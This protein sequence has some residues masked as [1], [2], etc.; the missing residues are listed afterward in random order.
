MRVLRQR[1]VKARPFGRWSLG[2][3][4]GGGITSVATAALLAYCFATSGLV[5]F[6]SGVPA[7]ASVDFGLSLATRQLLSELRAPL[8]SIIVADVLA[9]IWCWLRTWDRAPSRRGQL[10]GLFQVAVLLAHQW[11]F[12]TLLQ[13]ALPSLRVIR[14]E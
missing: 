6:L 2:T 8:R 1:E 5:L 14:V 12:S 11:L 7:W 13:L 10:V 3:A 9:A 4:E